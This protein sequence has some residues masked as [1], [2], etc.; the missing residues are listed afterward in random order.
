MRTT[1]KRF[2]FLA[3]LV[4][5]TS[6][7]GRGGIE[8]DLQS[9]FKSMGTTSNVTRGGAWR[10]QSGGYYS[11]GS[12]F[13]R[14]PSRTVTFLNVEPPSL[15]MNC[16]S[17]DFI[18]GG[19]SVLSSRQLMDALHAIGR[20]AGAYALQ[21]GLS[22]VT[23]QVKA[24]IDQLMAVLQEV[25]G[26]SQNSC[27][28]GQL[29]AAGLLPKNAAMMKDLCKSKGMSARLLEDWAGL[30]Q[31]CGTKAHDIANRPVAGFEDVLGGEYNLAWKALQKNAFLRADPQLAQLM[32]SVSGSLISRKA[33]GEKFRKIHLPSLMNNQSL[34]DALI[35]GGQDA[36]IYV[37]D[38]RQ[39]NRCLHPA[40]QRVAVREASSL[41]GKV[42]DLL[43]GMSR[44]LR[45][46]EAI[47]RE[48]Q[49]FV[50]ATSLPV[51][52]ILAIETAFRADG[53]PLKVSEFSEAIAYDL[54]LRYFS[55]ILDLVA[56]SLRDLEQ[57]QVDDAIIKEFRHDLRE[58]RKAV[59]D[60]RN[61]IY[62][63]MLTQLKMVEHTRQV[64]TRL[65]SLFLSL[66][67]GEEK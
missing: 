29:L 23:P 15:S 28:T 26:L 31:E 20:N 48:E 21:L 37:C 55:G 4:L 38:D 63:Q 57:V 12:V 51:M 16:G 45:R 10:D 9:F 35:Y 44:K 41:F 11:G 52:A 46:D 36:E 56:E 47:S 5:L 53:S 33:P 50:N 42:N 1:L 7:P 3:G 43:E 34:I 49:A 32:M 54:L 17:M 30:D 14:S 59:L 40:R 60:R 8:G 27:L 64:E 62:Q 25:N 6:T 19:F 39:E 66:N 58:A 67:H 22:I 61:G 24:V 18:L 65:Q 13:I 2:F